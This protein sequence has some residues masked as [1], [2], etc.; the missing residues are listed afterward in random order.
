MELKTLIYEKSDAVGTI[1]FNRPERMNAVTP[2]VCMDL[3]EILEVIEADDEVRCVVLT[4]AGRAFS[5]GGD[6]DTIKEFQIMGPPAS[7][8]RLQRSTRPMQQLYMLEKVTIAK[9]NGDAIGGGAS[10]AL[11]CDFVVAAEKARFGFVFSNIGIIPDMGC[12]YFL[13]RIVGLRMAK[14]LVFEGNIFSA[15]EAL[16]LGIVSEMVATE[17]LDSAVNSLAERMAGKPKDSMGLMKSIMQKGM[18]MDLVALI[19]REVEAQSLL[20]KTEDHKEGLQALLERRR[21]NFNL[22]D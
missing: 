14:K 17:D 2:Q 15:E 20:W 11:A 18:E 8:K 22:K 9:V 21:P 16:K 10:L 12:M 3:K 5:A 19:E 1:T 7:R 13:P 4:G 6:M